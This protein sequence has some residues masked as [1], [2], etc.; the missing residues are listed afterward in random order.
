LGRRIRELGDEET[1]AGQAVLASRFAAGIVVLRQRAVPLAPSAT[2]ELFGRVL[3]I[4]ECATAC[5]LE[6]VVHA[7]DL[8]VSLGVP[9]PAFT[10]PVMDLVTVTLCRIARARHGDLAVMRSLSRSERAPD[11]GVSAFSWPGD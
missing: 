5:L 4:D 2:V 8:A 10:E 1:A 11:G 7:D 9:P 6:L 3:R